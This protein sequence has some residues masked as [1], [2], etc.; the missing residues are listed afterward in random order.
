[1]EAVAGETLYLRGLTQMLKKRPTHNFQW[2]ADS[3]I[4]SFTEM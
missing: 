3:I 2:M 1:M 4:Y